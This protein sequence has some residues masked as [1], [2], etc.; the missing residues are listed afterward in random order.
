MNKL[1]RST[2]DR[3]LAGVCGGIAEYFNVDSTVIRIVTIIL[4]FPFSLLII[5]LYIIGILLM[6]NDTEVNEQ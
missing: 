4:A 6:P 1:T 2:R 3:K 5:S